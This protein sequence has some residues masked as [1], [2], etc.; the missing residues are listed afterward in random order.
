M[1]ATKLHL[2][3]SEPFRQAQDI[4]AT[5]KLD[6]EELISQTKHGYTP[7]MLA[8]LQ[9]R[10]EWVELLL[11]QPLQGQRPLAALRVMA[12]STNEELRAAVWPIYSAFLDRLD[13]ALPEL[14]EIYRTM[15]GTPAVLHLA[16]MIFEA[17]LVHQIRFMTLNGI[18]A[19]GDMTVPMG[20]KAFLAN[21]SPL[22]LFAQGL[23]GCGPPPPVDQE[24]ARWSAIWWQ[25]REWGV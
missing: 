20:V 17:D 24:D 22:A 19:M 12:N 13:P 11:S 5:S 3:C 9:G 21:R 16:R 8:T 25:F 10:P 1:P 14:F 18:R 6:P 7:L 4:T 2:A 23:W 15:T